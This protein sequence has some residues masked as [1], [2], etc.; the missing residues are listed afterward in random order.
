MKDFLSIQHNI[1]SSK[2]IKWDKSVILPHRV[3]CHRNTL[4]LVNS[5]V[6]QSS[7]SI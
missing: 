5:L 2:S 1:L 4:I 6:L 3:R 7:A